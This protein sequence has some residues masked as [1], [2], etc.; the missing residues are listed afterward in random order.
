MSKKLSTRFLGCGG[1]VTLFALRSGGDR[2]F[3]S[4]RFELREFPI[5][6]NAAVRDRETDQQNAAHKIA[7]QLSA[8][9]FDVVYERYSLWSA[10]PICRARELGIPTVLEVNAPLIEEQGAT[11]RTDSTWHSSDHSK[12]SLSSSHNHRGCF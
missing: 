1:Y 6:S 9:R 10:Q 5:G 11:S 4:S 12:S 2:R 7:Q 8:E 3:D